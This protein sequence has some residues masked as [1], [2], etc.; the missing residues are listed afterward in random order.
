MLKEDI[1]EQIADA[2]YNLQSK[3]NTIVKALKKNLN[4]VESGI[5]NMLNAIQMG[6]VTASTKQRLEELE[7]RKSEIESAILNEEIEHPILTK[8]QILFWISRFK[9][10]NIENEKYKQ[11][12]IDTFVNSVYLYDDKMVITYNF[13]DGTRTITL[14]EV[15]NSDLVQDASPVKNGLTMRFKRECEKKSVNLIPSMI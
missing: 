2:V 7:Q 11:M 14:D 5:N 13:K 12:L 9:D 10:G 8:E 1:I 3:E 4:E 15:E 6:I